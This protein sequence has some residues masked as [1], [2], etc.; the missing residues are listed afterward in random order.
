MKY[1]RVY[2]RINTPSYYNSNG[3][4]F[5]DQ[6]T[7]EKISGGSNKY[8]SKRWLEHQTEKNIIMV[9]NQ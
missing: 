5:E 6:Q 7:S 1:R 9:V 4:G 3:V 8:I 2:F